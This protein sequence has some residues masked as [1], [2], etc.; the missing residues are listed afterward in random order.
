MDSYVYFLVLPYICW[1]ASYCFCSILTPKKFLKYPMG[2]ILLLY[3][4]FVPVT[5]VLKTRSV[6]LG[7]ISMQILFISIISFFFQEKFLKKLACYFIFDITVTVVELVSSNLLVLIRH[8]WSA[9]SL[10]SLLMYRLSD[11]PDVICMSILDTVIGIFWVRKEVA[12]LKRCFSYINTKTFLQLLFPVFFPIFGQAML[13]HQ[14]ESVFF[15]F[16]VVLYWSF[17]VFSYPL[18]YR[19]LQNIQSQERIV[20]KKKHQLQ[21]MKDQLSFSRELEKGYQAL[22][23]WNHDV[24]NHLLSLSYLMDMKKYKEAI[25]YCCSMALSPSIN[26]A[27]VGLGSDTHS[28]SSTHTDSFTKA[29]TDTVPK[30]QLRTDTDID[31]DAETEITVQNKCKAILK[32]HPAKREQKPAGSRERSLLQLSYNKYLFFISMACMQFVWFLDVFPFF[33]QK[34]FQSL[35]L[36]GFFSMVILIQMYILIMK[37][38][39]SVHTD[40]EIAAVKKQTEL[41]EEHTAM[42]SERRKETLNIQQNMQNRIEMFQSLLTSEN[43]KEADSCLKETIRNFRQERYRPCCQDNLLNAILD[44]KKR[45][46]AKEHIR[47]DYEIL[48]PENCLIPAADLSSIIFNLLDNGIEACLHADS[49]DPFIRL[50]LYKNKEFLTIHMENS[51]NPDTPFSHK[52]TKE[53]TQSHGLG[54]SIIEEICGKYDGTYQW[55]DLGDIFDSVVLLRINE[56]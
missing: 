36:L 50:S 13:L 37:V 33:F 41:R 15:P 25:S 9:S 18:F 30:S 48:L 54:L 11:L 19:G 2:T 14:T 1:A 26:T 31:T 47:A 10:D 56:S 5:M 23:K 7:T 27:A 44:G 35:I 21:V 49:P 6:L 42:L 12:L 24:E 52:T 17:C 39:D 28:A 40:M 45:L 32:K 22:R 38:L 43:Y 55:R 4:I 46:A 8:L 51:K 3:F 34:A 16:L 20:N 53:D 29:E